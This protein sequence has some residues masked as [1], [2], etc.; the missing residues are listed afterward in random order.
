MLAAVPILILALTAP[1]PAAD[2]CPSPAELAETLNAR[3]PGLAPVAPAA[4]LS[5]ASGMRLSVVTSPE[6]DVRVDLVDAKD[7]IV[8]HR[9]LPAPPTGHAPD[10]P[11]LA[12]T[13]A[14]IVERYLHDVGYE[15]PTAPPPPAPPPSA[16]P[17]GAPTTIVVE[18]A[19]PAAAPRAHA[20]LWR[21][22][23]A[24]SGRRG[25]AGGFDGDGDLALGVEGTGEGVHVGARLSAG[26]AP[27]A[28][29]T[30]GTTDRATLLR[31]PFR[32]GGYVGV[33]LGRGRLEPGVGVG[34]DV[35]QV[36]VTGGGQ[37]GG[38]YL[39]PS[40][41]LSVTYTLPLIGAVYGR[42]LSRIA[43]AEPYTFKALGDLQVWGTPRVYGELGVELGVSFP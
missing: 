6:G 4:P 43:L 36:A 15:A 39:A 16:P 14:I 13:I 29:A 1:A 27:R 30:W 40:A 22:G 41:D 9:L 17:A 10:C 20:A 31:I 7:E 42:A 2:A 18:A 21:L 34:A 11:A 35:L 37:G 25:D 26:L 24:A 38:G 5:L 23:F 19:P 3:V 8:L 32:L 33:P 12:E 28:A